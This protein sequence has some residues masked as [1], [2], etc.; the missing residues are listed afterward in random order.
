METQTIGFARGVMAEEL[1]PGQLFTFHGDDGRVRIA[2]RV[3]FEKQSLALVL[4]EANT[5]P[6]KTPDQLPLLLAMDDVPVPLGLIEAVAVVRP[7]QDGEPLTSFPIPSHELYGN[8]VLAMDGHDGPCVTVHL[9]KGH[10]S[11]AFRLFSLRTGLDLPKNPDCV[12]YDEWELH[13]D[14]GA[15]VTTFV[16]R[17][18]D[19]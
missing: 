5:P 14:W 16:A 15:G 3:G 9:G 11:H 7:P 10:G 1:K 17:F 8:G 4:G 6:E 13:L 19:N 12:L 18:P 2:L